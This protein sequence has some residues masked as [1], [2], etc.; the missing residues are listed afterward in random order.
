MKRW[1]C[2]MVISILLGFV[3]GTPTVYGAGSEMEILLKKLVQ[4]GI[5]SQSEAEEIAKETKEAAAAQKEADKK[6]LKELAA[7]QKEA[8]KK[9][10]KE[11]ASKGAEL[12]D[13]IKN[14]KFNGDFRLRYQSNDLEGDDHTRERVRYRLR[15]GAE[16]KV[17]DT[18][19]A[20][21]GFV[22]SMP[23]TS[24]DRPGGDPRSGNFTLQDSFSRKDIWVDYAYA[25]WTP[26]KEFSIIGGKFANP[27][28]QPSDMLICSDIRPEGAA[29][30]LEGNAAD[31][32]NLFF[33]GG[34]FVL[35]E[36]E[37]G[38]DPLMYAL[39]AGFK[40]NITK[41]SFFRFA[42]AYYTFTQL[43]G[44]TVLE[45][46]SGKD[47][48]TTNTT[49]GTYPNKL[50][51]YDYNVMSFGGEFGF[52]KPFGLSAIPYLGIFAGQSHNSDP[53]EDNDA[54][55]VGF[56]IGNPDVRNAWDWSLEYTY[57]KMERDAWLDIFPDSNFY[58]GKTDVKGHRAMLLFGLM[59][60]TAFGFNYYNTQNITGKKK[61]ENLWQ[62]DFIFKF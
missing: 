19:T 2:L 23:G 46:V 60:N 15:L 61:T 32:F 10:L 3:F 37:K 4:K 7:A 33:N 31:N 21:F 59:K 14:I 35:D 38:P 25:R 18:V 22:T 43:K 47:Q 17:A 44:N 57:R 1:F 55:L 30:K 51:V 53:P 42:P 54:Y 58:G 24:A 34:L 36:R 45:W 52:A 5:L 13:W 29:I 20:G 26:I 50:Y 39:Q 16:T 62:G 27:I 56:S 28:W 11:L 49:T 48:G 12:P 8:D 6:E 41:D 9:E 40:W